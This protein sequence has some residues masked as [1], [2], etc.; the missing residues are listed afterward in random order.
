MVDSIHNII[1]K[2]TKPDITFLL[3]V[4]ISKAFER[5]KKRKKLNRYD[6]FSKKFY[7]KVQNGFIKLANSNKKRY[8]IINNS[9]DSIKVEKQIL[10]KI[11]KIL[12]K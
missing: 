3:T 9:N 4:Q 8:M 6:K 5:L 2:K 11:L 7:S 10:K 12:K 1:L